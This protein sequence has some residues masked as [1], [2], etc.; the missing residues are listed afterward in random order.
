MV[1]DE[2]DELYGEEN[3]DYDEHI[4]R[5][6]M[7]RMRQNLET[8]LGRELKNNNSSSI[9]QHQINAF[10]KRIHAYPGCKDFIESMDVIRMLGNSAAHSSN[11]DCNQL[12]QAECEKAV[13]EYRVQ[14][15]KFERHEEGE[16]VNKMKI[17]NEKMSKSKGSYED[18]IQSKKNALPSHA[19]NGC[20]TFGNKEE[21]KVKGD[22]RDTNHPGAT[23]KEAFREDNTGSANA[24]NR[25]SLCISKKDLIGVQ[26]ILS[27]LKGV[28]GFAKLRKKAKLAVKKLSKTT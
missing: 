27:E 20:E 23:G 28:P 19:N 3:Q 1:E 5:N 13:F 24:A 26:L 2:T 14:K 17:S 9:L 11:L 22:A 7:L 25:L 16:S 6:L 12:V 15:E 21:G 4:L 10:S 18:S 8:Y